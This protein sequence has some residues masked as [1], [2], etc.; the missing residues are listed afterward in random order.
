MRPRSVLVVASFIAGLVLSSCSGSGGLHSDVSP[1]PTDLTNPMTCDDTGSPSTPGAS[2]RPTG[3]RPTPSPA[4]SPTDPVGADPRRDAIPDGS[5]S[6]P[7]VVAAAG[8]PTHGSGVVWNAGGGSIT[9][10]IQSGEVLRGTTTFNAS[11]SGT[12]TTTSGGIGTINAS[13]TMTDGVVSGSA[14][15]IK[16]AGT[17][18]QSGSMTI[19]AQGASITVPLNGAVPFTATLNIVSVTCSLVTATFIPDLNAK[20]G[21]GAIFSGTAEW[22]GDRV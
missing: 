2:P 17:F 8:T 15:S 6:G 16:I 3:H 14:R 4:P 10:T 22:R 9:V 5:W 11:S 1:S 21:G 20:A 19:T 13:A 18:V 12:V 7:I